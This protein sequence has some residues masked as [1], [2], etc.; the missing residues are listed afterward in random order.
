LQSHSKALFKEL[1]VRR[2]DADE[3]DPRRFTETGHGGASAEDRA[4]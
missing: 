2:S 4:E 3:P 1:Q